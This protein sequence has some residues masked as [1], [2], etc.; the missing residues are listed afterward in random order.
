TFFGCQAPVLRGV[1]IDWQRPP[2][3]QGEIVSVDT[4]GHLADIRIDPEF[5][6]DGSEQ[7]RAI[8]T[9]DRRLGLLLRDGVDAYG[10]VQS[11]SAITSRILRVQFTRFIP[12]QPGQTVVLRHEIYGANAATFARCENVRVEDVTIG[13][14]PGMGIYAE[15]CNTI[16]VAGLCIASSA[17][18]LMSTTADGVHCAACSGRVVI[19][20]CTMSGMG[21]DGV[22]V[23]SQYL[24]IL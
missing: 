15:Q 10:V 24:R 12:L 17:N 16:S 8:A 7:I 22:N 3:S 2:F 13:T 23:H 6:V 19:R 18:R 11:S 21:D 20:D 5:P 1:T 14:A 9:Y 4:N